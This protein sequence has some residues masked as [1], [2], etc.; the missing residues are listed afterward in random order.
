MRTLIL[1]G[2]FTLVA[3]A[4]WAGTIRYACNFGITCDPENGCE[5][6]NFALDYSFDPVAYTAFMEGNNGLAEV[7]VHS[8]PDAIS[9]AEGLGTGVVQTTTVA[10]SG[11]SVHSR[12]T[13]IAGKLVPSQF[14]GFCEMSW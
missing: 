2:L 3:A 4:A 11:S 12:H 6:S 14:Y 13:I 7:V 10:L 9:F 1:S 8:G 5:S